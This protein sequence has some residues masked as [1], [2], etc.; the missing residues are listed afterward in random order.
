M[1][2]RLIYPE[3][4]RHLE[5]KLVTVITGLRRVGKTTAVKHL[6]EKVKS[7]NKLYLDLERVENRHLFNLPNYKDIELSLE[8][9]GLDLSKKAY[10]ALDEIQ[11]VPN[12]ASVV[13]YLYDTYNIKFIVTGSSSFYIKNRFTESL[14]G[15]KRIFE[16]EPLSFSEYLAFKGEKAPLPNAGKYNKFNLAYFNRYKQHYN[17]FLRFGGFPEVALAQGEDEMISYLKDIINSYIELDIKLLSDFALSDDLY[18]LILLLVERVGSKLDYSKLGSTMGIN[19][20]KMKD[21]VNLLE[22][23]Y[24]IKL[25]PPFTRN[26]DREIALQPK[27]YFADNGLLTALGNR[28]SGALLE[29]MVAIQLSRKGKLQYYSKK[30]GQEIDFILDGKTAF[31]V[32]ETPSVS[33]LNTLVHRATGIKLRE[34]YLIGAKQPNP[35]FSDF[36][37]AGTL[38]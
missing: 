37:W 9:E 24:F 12:I 4:E 8:A 29:N 25:L 21:Y 14:A 1:V 33:D 36:V 32:K 11:L 19:R 27:I 17:T 15:R 26:R 3:L 10:I 7:S 22:Y 34:H 23:T 30:T 13:K 38:D 16:M 20:Q 35:G 28:N 6:L 18:K 31:E 5:N 2:L